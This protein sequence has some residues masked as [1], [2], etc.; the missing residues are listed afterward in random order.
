MVKGRGMQKAT[1]AATKW[2]LWVMP[3]VI[4]AMGCVAD[5]VLNAAATSSQAERFLPEVCGLTVGMLTVLTFAMRRQ[6]YLV[7]G[8]IFVFVEMVA[9]TLH[10]PLGPHIGICAASLLTAAACFA[11]YLRGPW[12]T[13]DAVYVRERE[14]RP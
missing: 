14:N 3:V 4:F 1:D 8:A 6:A 12:T 5:L 10:M 11:V 13:A 2:V 7:A 9:V